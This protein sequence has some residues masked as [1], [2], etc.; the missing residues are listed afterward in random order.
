VGRRSRSLISGSKSPQG[1]IPLDGVGLDLLRKYDTPGPRYTSYPPAPAF[2]RAFDAGMYKSEIVRNNPP[3]STADLSLYIHIPFCDTLCYFCGC[4]AIVTKSR[5]RIEE[6]LEHLKREVDLVLPHVAGGRE[7]VQLHLGGGSPSCLKPQEIEDLMLF[8]QERFR[9]STTMEAGIE[10]DPRGLTFEHLLAMRLAGFN[11]ISIGVQDFEPRVLAAVNRVQP[12]ETVRRVFRWSRALE[13]TS[14]NFDLI[15]GLPHQSVESMQ[16][17]IEKVIEMSP[18]RIALFN[19]AYVPWMKPHQKLLRLEDFPS[20]EVKL[21]ILKMAIERLTAAGY[22]YVGMDHFAKPGDELA[23]AQAKKNLHRNFQGYSTKAGSDLYGFGMSAISHFGKIYSQNH[24][25]LKDYYTAIDAGQLPTA[26]GY[27]MKRDDEIRR[28][29]IMRL[30]CDLELTKAEVESHF[31]IDF[32]EYFDSDLERLNELANDG[33]VAHSLS[34]IR[35]T[36]TGRL[37]LRNIAMCFDATLNRQAEPAP[38]F[39]RTV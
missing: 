19:F 28:Y 39:S 30:M 35:V 3:G 38:I 14:I 1:A 31:D 17:T 32:D 29:V 9:F 26:V 18:D 15:Y 5:E 13:F 24:K 33:L 25:N 7:V 21:R 6:Y 20:P 4:T 34:L 37:F 22:I 10:I 36:P 16:Q 11:R 27:R 12:E 23:S 2:T 8:L